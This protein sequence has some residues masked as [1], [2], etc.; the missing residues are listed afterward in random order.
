M[1]EK[2]DCTNVFF[3]ILKYKSI[4]NVVMLCNVLVPIF[5][6]KTLYIANIFFSP[7]KVISNVE[8][9]YQI[10][11]LTIY[12]IKINFRLTISEQSEITAAHSFDEERVV[13][14]IRFANVFIRS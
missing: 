1:D 10:V 9:K 11:C 8:F 12:S 3:I 13:Q 7:S 14:M 2:M 5:P 4:T 6:Y